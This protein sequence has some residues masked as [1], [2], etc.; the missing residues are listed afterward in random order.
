MIS[1]L[2][3]PYFLEDDSQAIRFG[4]ERILLCFSR[5]SGNWLGIR[6]QRS[7][8]WLAGA[9]PRTLA[10]D[11]AST[12]PLLLRAGGTMASAGIIRNSRMAELVGARE[13]GAQAVL[14]TYSADGNDA[15]VTLY[16]STNEG[17]WHITSAY[18][19]NPEGLVRRW[20]ILAFRESEPAILRDVRLL[21][22]PLAEPP[23]EPAYL[24][25]PGYPVPPHFPLG[26]IPPGIWPGLNSRRQMTSGAQ[27]DVDAPGSQTGLVVSSYPQSQLNLLV[28]P[29]TEVEFAIMELERKPGGLCLSQWLLASERMENGRSITVGTQYFRIEQRTLPDALRHLRT[30]YPASPM[31][32]DP[33]SWSIGT[34]IYEAHVGRAPF[35]HG[36]SYAPYPVVTRLTADLER[37]RGLGFEVL[38]VMPHFPYPGYSVHAYEDIGVQYG[39]EVSLKS[40]VARAH[41]LGLRVILDV[42]LHGVIDREIIRADMQ[43]FGPHY[44]FI[45]GAWLK[46]ADEQARLR[47]E[48]P[49]WFIRNEDGSL[50]RTYTWA[51]DLAKLSLQTYL[52]GVLRSYLTNLEV[53]GFR[54]D[55]PTWNC[56]PNWKNKADSRPSAA[57]YS[58]DGLLRRIR[59]ELKADYPSILLYTEPAGPLF[60]RTLDAVYNYD[61]EWLSASLLPVISPRGYAGTRCQVADRLSARQAADWLEYRNLV[62]VG[63][64][65]TVHHLDSHDTYWWGELAQFRAEAFGTPAARAMFAVYAL[66]GGG[67][68]VYAGAE[69]GAEDFYRAVLHL[70]QNLPALRCGTCDF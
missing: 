19:V 56:L 11:P 24:E 25:A 8:L 30:I 42:V 57:Y 17:G 38:Q 70:R 40:L 50:A 64:A 41:Q 44:D 32:N 59:A 52:I 21:L 39:D 27:H 35:L 29:F 47:R 5:A 26:S 31:N 49:G 14:E 3:A 53:D 65:Q 48:H 18:Q 37:I 66:Q 36:R 2:R 62:Q 23:G 1:D 10:R 58:A 43:A 68:M 55:A 22:P 6:D 13:I 60:R 20:V 15:S 51:F 54:F 45:F 33:P 16:V 67:L 9:D 28:W 63:G 34:A 12:P 46:Q 4:N 7:G 61:E 69:G